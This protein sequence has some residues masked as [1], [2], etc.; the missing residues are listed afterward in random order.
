M[1]NNSDLG[2]RQTATE[3]ENLRMAVCAYLDYL[4]SEC[5]RQKKRWQLLAPYNDISKKMITGNVKY[6]SHVAA[7]LKNHKQLCLAH[8]STD[9]KLS[10]ILQALFMM[11]TTNV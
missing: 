7:W 5:E 11:E 4:V 6:Y 10:E 9:W 2:R 1:M 8:R 3:V